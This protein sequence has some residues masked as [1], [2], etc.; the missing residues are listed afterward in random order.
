[1][2]IHLY[3][4]FLLLLLLCNCQ[5]KKNTIVFEGEIVNAN[6]RWLYLSEISTDGFVLLDS[7]LIKNNQFRI[8]LWEKNE[9]SRLRRSTPLFYQL[10][11]DKANALVTLTKNGETL[12]IQADGTDLIH[13]YTIKGGK[14]AQ[15]MCELEQQLALFIDST[16]VL[17]D[18]YQYEI[19]D[20][21]VRERVEE[22]YVTLV[23]NHTQFLLHFIEQNPLSMATIA[24]FYQKYNRKIFFPEKENIE[25]LKQIY[26]HLVTLY[27]NNE[28]VEF[29]KNRIELIEFNIDT[30]E[31]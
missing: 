4:S 3:L 22:V 25:L 2:K 20:D 17:Y 29:V 24:A 5:Q 10:S 14:D 7:C 11:L 8:N 16:D 12:Q 15:L 6:F 31:K 19:E 9:D 13:T 28:N 27:P 30:H 21:A 26:Q 18:I 1:M 23:K